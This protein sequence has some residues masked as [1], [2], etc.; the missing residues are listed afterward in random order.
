MDEKSYFLDHGSERKPQRAGRCLFPACLV[1][2]CV[3]RSSR[4]LTLPRSSLA[5]RKETLAQDDRRQY[6]KQTVISSVFEHDSICAAVLHIEEVFEE[7]HIVNGSTERIRLVGI[8]TSRFRRLASVSLKSFCCY[9][10]DSFF[11]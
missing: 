3:E 4:E 5:L 6:L 1:Q 7:G 2:G 11:F 9:I 8:P 10:H